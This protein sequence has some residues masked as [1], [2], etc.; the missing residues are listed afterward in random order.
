MLFALA[1]RKRLVLAEALKTAYSPGFCK[2]VDLVQSGVIGDVVDVEACFT[3]LTPAG[4]RERD[5]AVFGGSF[6]ELGS[7]AMLPALRLLG[8]DPDEVRFDVV[9]DARGIDMFT[10]VH[11]RFGNAFACGKVGLGAKSEGELVVTGTRGAIVVSAPWWKPGHC[12]VHFEDPSHIVA[13]DFEFAGDGLRYE[14]SDFTHRILEHAGRRQKLPECE[15]LAMA[16]IMGA[17]MEGE[18][19]MEKASGT[20]AQGV[21]LA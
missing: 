16:R 15:S 13:Y 1:K 5:D 14:V 20:T 18:G 8:S 12:E 11:L 2:I 19:R 17:F 3:R 9:R 10:K 6:L 21:D 7:Y 4:C